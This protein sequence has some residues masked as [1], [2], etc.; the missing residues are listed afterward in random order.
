[1]K[2]APFALAAVL[3]LAAATGPALAQT[4]VPAAEWRTPDPENVL[5]FETSKGRIIV[6]MVP[7]AAPAHVERVR[8]LAR[9]GFYDGLTFFR[10]IEGFMAQTGDPTNTGMGGAE[11]PD[12]PAEFPFRRGATPAFTVIDRLPGDF[13]TPSATEVG[14][15][16]VLPVRSLPSMQMMLAADGRVTS[17]GLFCS[18]VMGMARANSPDS[19]NSQFFF[20]RGPYPSLDNNY[21]AWGRVIVGQDTVRALKT[22]EPVA[23][24]QD[25]MKTVRVLADLPAA[26][27]PKVQVLDV[28]GPTF[29]ALVADAKS[30]AQGRPLNPCDI[31]IPAKV[32]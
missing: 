24:P 6:E 4:P 14:F 3:S 22:G 15:L 5:V 16:G 27:R 8:T 29:R 9:A 19:A 18:G 17:W 28:G 23:S 12:L 1:M 7:A 25:V 26:Q 11:L 2:V 21:T 10:V 30:K 20:M 32:G 13:S 31:E